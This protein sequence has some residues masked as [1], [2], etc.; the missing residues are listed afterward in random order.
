MGI[1]SQIREIGSFCVSVL[2]FSQVVVLDYSC[3][4]EVIAKLIMNYQRD[5]RP[6]DAYFVVRGLAEEHI[7]PIEEVLVRHKLALV[8]ESDG[9][10]VLLGN[11]SEI[12]RAV[13]YE[14]EKHRNAE[15]HELAR[16]VG[17]TLPQTAFA[18]D[19]LHRLRCVLRS[20]TASRFHS[21]SSLLK[22]N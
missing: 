8:A 7:E 17:F 5:E 15:P 9:A 12:E 19:N 13:W 6:T 20:G 4:D 2:D 16:F 22:T 3:A 11:V 10:T 14:L 21:L 18:L 1:E